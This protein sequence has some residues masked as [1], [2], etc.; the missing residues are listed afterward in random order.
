MKQRNNNLVL[1][2]VVI[3]DF[4]LIVFSSY[5]HFSKYREFLFVE[6]IVPILLSVAFS[7]ICLTNLK[8]YSSESEEGKSFIKRALSCTVI[9]YL[10]LALTLFVS[11][12]TVETT[13]TNVKEVDATIVNIR[14]DNVLLSNNGSFE[15]IK[16]VAGV[17]GLNIGDKITTI[18][19][20]EKVSHFKSW[21]GI[22]K[23][24]RR[25]VVTLKG[26]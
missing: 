9:G 20:E 11:T 21:T 2:I 22:T 8:D 5:L 7:F 1:N 25:K 3:L 13:S 16:D 23:D 12:K 24:A 26:S 15:V 4:A 6:D 18:S 19:Y 10:L 17:K 14:K